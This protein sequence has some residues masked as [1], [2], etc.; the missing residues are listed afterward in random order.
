MK[1]NIN[2]YVYVKLT[3]TGIDELKRQH[4]EFSDL[5]PKTVKEFELKTDENGYTRFQLWC[6]IQYLGHLC[7]IGGKLP[8]ET[9]MIIK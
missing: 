9:E 8:F 3:Q 5:F 2:D 7:V 1:I 4:N 6:L